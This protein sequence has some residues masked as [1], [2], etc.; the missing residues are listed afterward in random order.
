MAQSVIGYGIIVKY[1]NADI[2]NDPI[3]EVFSS[4]DAG[5]DDP[6][7]VVFVTFKNKHVV[8]RAEAE[9]GDD[10][11]SYADLTNDKILPTDDDVKLFYNAL[12]KILS[13]IGLTKEAAK[14]K[15]MMFLTTS[16]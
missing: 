11:Y 1:E 7:P 12:L 5:S 3:F 6:V 15:F 16:L 14:I 8:I 10:Q 2:F 13:E 9:Q 4:S